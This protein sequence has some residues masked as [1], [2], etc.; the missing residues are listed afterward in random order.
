MQVANVRPEGRAG[1][2]IQLYFYLFLTTLRDSL[3]SACIQWQLNWCEGK[4]TNCSHWTKPTVNKTSRTIWKIQARVPK[5]RQRQHVPSD[6]LLR[7][8][9]PELWFWGQTTF[10]CWHRTQVYRPPFFL[11]FFFFFLSGHVNQNKTNLVLLSVLWKRRCYLSRLCPARGASPS[12][13]L[14]APGSGSAECVL[15][16]RMFGTGSD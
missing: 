5:Q 15:S 12:K 8:T 9:V 4:H 16:E 7:R 2:L 14:L 3:S 6:T 13:S 11:F 10:Q 1:P